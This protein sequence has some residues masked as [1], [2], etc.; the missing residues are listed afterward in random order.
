MKIIFLVISLISIQSLRIKTN[1]TLLINSKHLNNITENQE[2]NVISDI[3]KYNRTVS[4][5]KRKPNE[6]SY[7]HPVIYHSRTSIITPKTI[8]DIIQNDNS[9]S[10]DLNERSKYNDNNN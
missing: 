7:F 10:Y 9:I 8:N 5:N 4:N 6:T 1:S 2:Q 3:G